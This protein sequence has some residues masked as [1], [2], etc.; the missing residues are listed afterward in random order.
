MLAAIA[1][2][3]LVSQAPAADPQPQPGPTQATAAT[4]RTLHVEGLPADDPLRITATA[5]DARLTLRVTLQEGWH[6]YG[7]DT[8]KGQPVELRVTAGSAFAAAGTPELPMDDAGEISG[9]A[10]L[11]LPLRRTGPGDGLVV[12]FTFMA[13][14]ALEC[15]PPRE[16][17]LRAGSATPAAPA[18]TEATISPRQDGSNGDEC[19]LLLVTVDDAAR[20]DRIAAFLR[21]R[22]F[23]VTAT[24][25]GDVTTEQCDRHDVVLAD[26]P[27]FEQARKAYRAA[28]AFPETTAPIVAV[29][30][31][32]TTLLEA[33]R[34][35]MACGYI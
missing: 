2:L 22:R 31:L 4:A 20:R 21:Q 12:S 3:L 34:I 5:T 28:Q 13:C 7:R 27:Y 29:G 35:A 33:Q 11:Q 16:V 26:S 15:L 19:K 6:L 1:A 9:D 18:T 25:Y 30:Y 10:V 24:T 8:G 23:A 32:G 14:D 17:T